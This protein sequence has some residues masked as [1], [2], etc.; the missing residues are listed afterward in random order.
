MAGVKASIEF[1][2]QQGNGKSLGEKIVS[3]YET[4][5]IHERTLAEK[6][7]SGLKS[8]K[9]ITVVGQPFGSVQ[10]SPTI[11]F[12]KEGK[13]AR[14]VCTALGAQNICAWDG[15][16]YAIRSIEVLGLLEKGGVTRMGI[17]IYNTEEEI[18]RTLDSISKL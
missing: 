10:R 4:I 13:T 9:G 14:E 7:Y 16:F 11:S 18:D 6:L 2:A 15:H 12:I 8:I 3:A 5:G 17:S 1:I